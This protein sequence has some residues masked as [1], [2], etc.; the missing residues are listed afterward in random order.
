[1][2][3]T[4]VTEAVRFAGVSKV[5]G[6][7][8]ALTDIDLGIPAGLIHAFVGENGAGTS[9]MAGIL[10]GKVTPTAGSV[11][12]FGKPSPVGNP[13]ALK[14]EGVAMIYQELTLVPTLSTQANLF[15]GQWRNRAGFLSEKEM[16]QTLRELGQRLGVRITPDVAVSTLPI[17]DQQILEILRAQL[18]DPRLVI[19]DE[20]TASLTFRER[21]ALAGVMFRLREQGVTQI[22]VSHDLPEVLAIAD[23]I[24]VFRDGRLVDD[25]GTADWT[26][27]E[28]GTAIRGSS[29]TESVSATPVAR[30]VLEPGREAVLRLRELRIPHL[31]DGIDL[32]LKP[33]EI[34]GITGI[35]GA[36]HHDVLRALAGDVKRAT[37][38]LT[39]DGRSIP[40]PRTP[41]RAKTRGIGYISD[42]R[43]RTGV[44]PELTSASNVVLTDLWACSTAG[45]LPRGREERYGRKAAQGLRVPDHRWGVAAGKL[46]GGTQQKLLVA[47]W[48]HHPVRVLLANEPT[49][50][51]D[52]GAK[53]EIMQILKRLAAEGVAVLIASGE[54]E[55]LVEA[56]DRVLVFHDGRIAEEMHT[57][58]GTVTSE[59]IVAS[60]QRAVAS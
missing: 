50:G 51:I 29:H 1:M 13:K 24:T 34:V 43:R 59:A 26:A 14:S 60:I 48:M 46:S 55:E 33:G 57:H 56:S 25:R 49:K 44:V 41:R 21:R 23:R 28:L 22:L 27:R 20:P 15:L 31:V 32:D 11:T 58:T 47:R 40:L 39:I 36:G 35:V 16:R 52:I 42:D 10:S 30:P 8:H 7:T 9:T 37:G 45:L 18:G 6:G 17:A 3:Q 19:Y 38:R 54:L 53:D 5:Y 4:E 12:L 2:L